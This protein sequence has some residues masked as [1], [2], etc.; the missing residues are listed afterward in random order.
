MI[1][2]IALL[3]AA[4]DRPSPEWTPVLHAPANL[5]HV[6]S[7]P[8]N[9]HPGRR[10]ELRGRVLKA[11]RRTPAAGVILYFHHTD[12]TGHYPRPAGA[13]PRDWV[14]WHGSLRGWLKT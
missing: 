10:M 12:G 7:I 11:D 6:L 5:T 8:P 2:A 4:Q 3:L 1:A 9:A 14:Y 13:S